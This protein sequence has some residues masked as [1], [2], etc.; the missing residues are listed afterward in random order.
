MPG[1]ARLELLHGRPLRLA[2]AVAL[3]LRRQVL[4]PRVVGHRLR[5]ERFFFL[6]G[7]RGGALTG[8]P[9]PSP[10]AFWAFAGLPS[11]TAAAA[12]GSAGGLPRAAVDL[13]V[14]ASAGRSG[15][16]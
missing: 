15:F 16:G 8:P 1:E 11:A 2:E 9:L 5:P 10:L 7:E 4:R 13:G 6:R 12:A 3:A 14:P